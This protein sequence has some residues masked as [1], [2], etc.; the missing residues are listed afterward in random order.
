MTTSNRASKFDA[1]YKSL[2]KH[3]KPASEVPERSVLEHLLYAC[4]LE[5]ARFDQ[6]DEAFAKLQQAY[7]DWN[8]VRVTT[9]SELG[10]SLQSLP[11]AAQA[12]ARI[13]QC[14]Q[15]LFESRYQYDIDDLKKANL[16]KAVAELEAWKG[17][18]PFVVS[19]VSQQALGGHSI[20]V[21]YMVLQALLQ[22]EI[23]TPAE[24][25]KK[26]VPGLERAIPK[27]KG[28]EFGSLLQQF[29]MEM[30]AHPKSNPVQSVL[31]DLGVT[32]KAKPKTEPKAP[33]QAAK[34]SSK[35]VAPPTKSKSVPDSKS[36]GTPVSEAVAPSKKGDLKKPVDEQRKPEK[37]AKKGSDKNEPAPKPAAK[38]V[39]TK[40]M[41]PPPVSKE[42]HP[43]SNSTPAKKNKT[44]AEE[45][46][47]KRIPA[48]PDKKDTKSKPATKSKSSDTPAKKTDGSKGAK[49][50]GA[51]KSTTGS[52]SSN[53]TKKKPK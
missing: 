24:A 10:E 52:I 15:A 22:C 38:P 28:A 17:M 23:I 42:K 6:A 25:E 18:S 30:H 37:P 12:A 31:K 36:K 39:V 14:L 33:E 47:Q 4:C 3:F 40:K 7:F 2:K 5:D 19:Y 44:G 48:K 26:S 51:G 21:S 43:A 46:T 1:L 11:F 9:T 35:S 50:S 20:P 16:G 29:A 41:A 32:Y 13:K 53:L 34:P 27:N 45:T 8:E 49:P